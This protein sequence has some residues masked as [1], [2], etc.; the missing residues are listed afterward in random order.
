[1]S[2]SSWARLGQPGCHI[3]T[4]S[5][6]AVQQSSEEWR[7]NQ[8]LYTAGECKCNHCG[9]HTHTCDVVSIVT[10]HTCAHM[11]ERERRWV[12]IWQHKRNQDSLHV[13]VIMQDTKPKNCPLCIHAIE[14]AL[15]ERMNA[16]CKLKWF[17]SIGEDVL[18]KSSVFICQSL[19]TCMWPSKKWKVKDKSKSNKTIFKQ[20]DRAYKLFSY[21]PTRHMATV[22]Y[23]RT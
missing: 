22:K 23:F 3:K 2:F 5:V 1:M 8:R 7:G 11:L 18:Y 19:V 12:R 13:R 10:Q 21:R 4:K 15:C 20:G 14:N 9:N 17:Q 6:N 16:S